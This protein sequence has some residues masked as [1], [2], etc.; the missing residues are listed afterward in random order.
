MTKVTPTPMGSP[1][2]ISTRTVSADPG[3][4]SNEELL[5]Q[6]TG[7]RRRTLEALVAR[8]SIGGLTSSTKEK[9]SMLFQRARTKVRW[10]IEH[11]QIKISVSYCL[12]PQHQ[13]YIS[14]E[15]HVCSH[16][17]LLFVSTMIS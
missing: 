1:T 14:S 5:K 4:L 16:P 8:E 10:F 3:L 11:A 12:R 17:T 2:A 7:R 13:I 15:S 9:A 6:H